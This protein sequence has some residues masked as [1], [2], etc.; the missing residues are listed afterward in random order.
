MNV[1]NCIPPAR[2]PYDDMR[3]TP[4]PQRLSAKDLRALISQRAEDAYLQE[5]S[6]NN[7]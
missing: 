5:Y 4:P 3:M 6:E 1:K 2:I 7:D